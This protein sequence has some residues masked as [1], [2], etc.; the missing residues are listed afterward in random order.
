M[1]RQTALFA[2]IILLLT[3]PSPAQWTRL[4]GPFGGM[5]TSTTFLGSSPV[6][7]SRSGEIYIANAPGTTWTFRSTSPGLGTVRL[8][9]RG[10]TM[11]AGTESSLYR[12]VDSGRTWHV[13]LPY[14]IDAL[15]VT[16]AG[17]VI[18]GA[19]EIESMHTIFVS[20]DDGETWL[21]YGDGVNDV[22]CAIATMNDTLYAGT[23]S[24]GILKSTDDG[25]TWTLARNGLPNSGGWSYSQIR[26]LV[27]TANTLVAL[28]NAKV[29]RSTDGGVRWIQVSGVSGGEIIVAT[30]GH[31]FVANDGILG[32]SDRGIT[33]TRRD[34]GIRNLYVRSLSAHDS[35]L[36]AATTYGVYRSTDLGMS[37]SIMNTG[38]NCADISS[39]A[40]SDS[41]VLATAGSG[42]KSDDPEDSWQPLGPPLENSTIL[43]VASHHADVFA[44]R[45]DQPGVYRSTDRGDHWTLV[46]TSG[47]ELGVADGCDTMFA[48]GTVEASEILY[49]SADNGATWASCATLDDINFMEM[50]FVGRTVYICGGLGRVIRST[51]MGASWTDVIRPTQDSYQA[52]ASCGGDLFISSSQ[53]GILRTTDGGITW[54]LANDGLPQEAWGAP[55]QVVDLASSGELLVAAT[56]GGGIAV[57]TDRGIHWRTMNAGLSGMN[58]RTVEIK[59][60][61]LYAGTDGKGLWRRPLGEVTAAQE[62]SPPLLPAS[63]VL[64]QNYPNPFNPS[65][66]MRFVLAEAADVR[67]EVYDIL[68]RFVAS[69]VHERQPAGVHEASFDGS[70]CASGIY[71]ARLTSGGRTLT[72]TMVLMR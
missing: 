60:G 1:N 29:Y 65:T 45:Y 64:E 15:T 10:A 24:R 8:S 2:V 55:M 13:A 67:L 57:S 14:R 70:R 63:L 49:R 43:Q 48:V 61:F 72:R 17:R 16:P 33:W 9:S 27:S 4:N 12:S 28:A 38:L 46:L 56:Q 51:D 21:P 68:G 62:A 42:F 69:L 19:F 40:F 36:I 22:V 11:F 30:T 50:A 5:C 71:I 32:S 37:W 7:H 58:I 23:V 66:T 39:I 52:I 25:V 34:A 44:L 6:A 59:A 31:V 54:T 18:V 26:G 41:R 47:Y 53:I 35:T 3:S 20:D